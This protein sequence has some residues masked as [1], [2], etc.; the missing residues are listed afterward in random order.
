MGGKAGDAGDGEHRCVWREVGDERQGAEPEVD[1]G[2][3]RQADA[4]LDQERID[5]VAPAPR[6]GQIADRIEQRSQTR[7]LRQLDDVPPAA[8]AAR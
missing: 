2:M 8:A 7:V 1:V 5:D 3:V 6:I 4:G